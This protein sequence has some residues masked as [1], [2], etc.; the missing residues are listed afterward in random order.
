MRFSY[1]EWVK[2]EKTSHKVT[3]WVLNIISKA[4]EF[5]KNG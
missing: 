2:I 5:S 3:G 1:K 4:K